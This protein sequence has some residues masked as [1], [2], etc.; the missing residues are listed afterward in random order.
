MNDPSTP[1]VAAFEHYFARLTALVQERL[2]VEWQF[3]RREDLEGLQ[4]D[5]LE[6]VREFGAL[7][8]VVYHY[9]LTEA[10]GREA[11]W[12]ASA[13]KSRGPGEDALS[14]LLDSWIVAVQGLIKPP[15]CNILAKPL[16]ELRA[17]LAGIFQE[18][19]SR[20]GTAPAPHISVLVDRLIMGDHPGARDLLRARLAAGMPAHEVIVSM[21]LPAMTEVGR[22]WELNELAIFEEHLATETVQRLILGLSAL[23]PPVDPMDRTA[24]V[25]C[26]PFDEH[27]TLPL[28]LGTF[29]ELRGW[30]V[31]S[32][33]R[34]LP[35]K[36]IGK[37][38]SAL[39]PDTIFLSLAMLSRLAVALDLVR[40]LKEVLPRSPIFIGGRGAEPGRALLEQVGAR[41][42]QD[43]DE[44]HR[45]AEQ[46]VLSRA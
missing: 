18:A 42:I 38:A 36:E 31:R 40:L 45:R 32:L 13:L 29:L 22:R 46:G 2:E 14:L 5:L 44:A 39:R 26:V 20:R 16:Q 21:L 19:E 12:Y 34:S 9:N 4:S 10:L 43:F 23:S 30:Q 3:H 27:Q 28:A 25:S 24:L 7:L 33:G 15:E 6:L 35:A 17:N 41:V 1:A 37:A 11:A 8:R